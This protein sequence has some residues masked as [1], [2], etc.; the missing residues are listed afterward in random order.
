VAMG[1]PC[2][3]HLQFSLLIN[4]GVI[5]IMFLDENERTN[6]GYENFGYVAD[7]LCMHLH[8]YIFVTF[9]PKGVGQATTT[10]NT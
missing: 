7:I 10:L 3:S 8:T 4:C 6:I 5:C 1:R 2:L 9:I